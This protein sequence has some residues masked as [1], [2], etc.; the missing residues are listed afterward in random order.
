MSF[1][2][3]DKSRPQ[4]TV[5]T[6][7]RPERMN[8]MAFDVMLPLRNA[9]EEVSNDNDTRVVGLPGAGHRFCS[10]ADLEACYAVADRIS[11]FSRIGIESTKRLLW[12]SLEAGS[13]LGH[14][15]HEAQAQ[16]YVRMTTENFEEAIRARKER[17]P[18]VFRD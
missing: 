18:P 12:S 3:I 4:V 7:N 17:R 13:L 16:L 5:I 11:A 2:L 14:M 8:A 10:R 1:V 15:D 9:L 6:L